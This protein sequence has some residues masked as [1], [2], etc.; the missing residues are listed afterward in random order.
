MQFTSSLTS[1][2]PFILASNGQL[3]YAAN[4]AYIASDGGSNGLLTFETFAGIEGDSGG[5]PTCHL[6]M[7]GALTANLA[8]QDEEDEYDTFQIDG[9][10][11][12]SQ[13]GSGVAFLMGVAPGNVEFDFVVTCVG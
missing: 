13:G 4:T 3:L 10:L 1:A 6:D 12:G 7:T 9:A 5:I 2:T 11:A 8:C